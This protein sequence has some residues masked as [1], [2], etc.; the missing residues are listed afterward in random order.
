MSL[1]SSPAQMSAAVAVPAPAWPPPVRAPPPGAAAAEKEGG[2]ALY[3]TSP[4]TGAA[5]SHLAARR[6][7]PLTCAVAEVVEVPPGR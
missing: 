1:S 7:R 3:G 4:V 2:G 5:P 6:K